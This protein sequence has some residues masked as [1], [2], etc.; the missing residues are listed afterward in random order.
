MNA[1]RLTQLHVRRATRWVR[2]L[3]AIF[4]LVLAWVMW[5]RAR[6]NELRPIN[7]ENSSAIGSKK[8]SERGI[9]AAEAVGRL[10]G[11]ASVEAAAEKGGSLFCGPAFLYW[12]AEGRVEALTGETAVRGFRYGWLRVHGLDVEAAD[13]ATA[14]PDDDGFSNAE[15]YGDGTQPTD[16][17]DAAVH[18]QLITKVRVARAT[19]LPLRLKFCGQMELHG[20]PLFQ[21][22][23]QAAGEGP[24]SRL[25][26]IGAKIERLQLVALHSREPAEGSSG[27]VIEIY[28]GITN[29]TLWLEQG[30]AVELDRVRAEFVLPR[31]GQSAWKVTAASGEAFSTPG[32]PP[33]HYV[34]MH[35]T[36]KG[37]R[38]WPYVVNSGSGAESSADPIVVPWAE[39][40]RSDL[41]GR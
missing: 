14:D 19:R 7:V 16:P 26:P 22:N 6:L 30:K 39:G 38:V 41:I 32:E 12:L 20:K 37:V 34:V 10:E 25:L 35:A 40:A 23:W 15:E 18:P 21:L 27:P 9:S 31:K 2:V 1:N 11:S 3:L 29:E 33:D 8:Q 24:Q 13:L 28:D 17:R 5:E 36:E 4:V